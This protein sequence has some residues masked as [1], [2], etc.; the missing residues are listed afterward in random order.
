MAVKVLIPGPLRPLAGG[1][2][3]VEVEAGDVASLIEGLEQRH[4]G[5]RER[6]CDAQ[7]ALRAYV[8]VFVNDEDVRFLDGER[9]AL[10]PGDSVA[11]VPAIAG[12]SDGASR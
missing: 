8:R 3:Q 7:G 2:D 12:G 5:F 11:I 6:L 10:R 4:H 1:A 9:T